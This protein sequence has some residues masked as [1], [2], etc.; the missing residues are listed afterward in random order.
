MTAMRSTLPLPSASTAGW[1]S[2]AATSEPVSQAGT[3]TGEVTLN[4]P[5]PLSV[6]APPQAL[7]GLIC[8]GWP[9]FTPVPPLV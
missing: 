7:S 5:L 3:A 2:R 1:P 8:T 6:E 9:G 4:V